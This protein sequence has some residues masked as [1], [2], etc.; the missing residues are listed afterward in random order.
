MIDF[1]FISPTKIYFE[2]EKEN[3]IGTIL[4]ERNAHKVLIVAGTSSIFS[5]GLYD[6][7]IKQLNNENISYITFKGVRANPTKSKAK[8]GLLLARENNIDYILAI[9]GGSVIDTA[10]LIA[11]TYN[12]DGDIFDFNMHKAKPTSALPIGVILTISASGSELSSSC[13]IQD[14]ELE[15]KKGFNSDLV[16]PAF[17][18]ENPELTYTV[19]KEQTAYG[20]VD[21]FMHT[22]ERYMQPS[23]EIEPADGFAET[24]VKSVIKA[25]AIAYE[26]PND[27][28]SRAIL[29]LMSSLSHNGL[30][31]IGK[32]FSMP[33]HQLE[34]AISGKYPF[35]AHGAGLAILFAKWSIYYLPYEVDKFDLFAR[36]VFDL[37]NPDKYQ[38]GLEGI[39]KMDEFF[40]SLNM[41]KTFKDLGII[42]VDVVSL[43]KLVSDNGKRIIHQ[44]GKDM[45][46][47]VM[48][49]IYN[50]CL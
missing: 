31:S 12:Y 27:Y 47:S 45:D 20:I 44:K 13:V 43:S 38:N 50:M 37:H 3:E 40:A 34:H 4:K 10:K 26:N 5:S 23:N 29:M 46:E 21:I 35:V 9:G 11:C 48:I 28:Q 30:T 49:E 25:G 14:D 22:F 2:K 16:R 17:V 42:D 36:N 6:R 19:S 8:E 7:V 41:P 39:K 24:V 32:S 18:I 15:I 33:I 1:D